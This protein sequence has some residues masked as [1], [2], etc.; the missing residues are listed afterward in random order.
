MIGISYNGDKSYLTILSS[1]Q[2]IEIESNDSSYFD[3]SAHPQHHK[4][5]TKTNTLSPTPISSLSPQSNTAS[6]GIVIYRRAA[7]PLFLRLQDDTREPKD[8]KAGHGH[9]KLR[10]IDVPV[11]RLLETA[12]GVERDRRRLRARRPLRRARRRRRTRI[13]TA[14]LG[15]AH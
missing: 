7:P 1:I 10:Q 5:P 11:R 9:G 3:F 14:A 13:R 2:S 15:H 8:T 6:Y 12:G 4:S